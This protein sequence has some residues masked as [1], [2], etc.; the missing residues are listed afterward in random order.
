M[1][2]LSIKY[3]LTLARERNFTRAAEKLYITQQT[4]SAHIAALE[5]ET[6]GPLFL[7]RVPL[8]LTGG[9]EVFYRYALVFEE[10]ERE[11]EKELALTRG[12]MAGTLRIGIALARGR[13]L[14]PPIIHRYREKYP[15]IRIRLSEDS[16]D[17]LAGRL[18]DRELDLVIARFDGPVA[19]L[20]QIPF[21]EEKI[22]L[23]GEERF[24][25][26]CLGEKKEEALKAAE[27]GREDWLSLFRSCPVLLNGKRDIIGSSVRALYK[28]AGFEPYISVES[29][30]V[31]TLLELCALGEGLFFC[32]E[33]LA[34]RFLTKEN[35]KKVRL[36]HFKGGPVY[37]ISFAVRKQNPL[38]PMTDSFIETAKE[39]YEEKRQREE[40]ET[41]G[42]RN[43][44]PSFRG[45]DMLQ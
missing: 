29:E 34:K 35:L 14:L 11:L 16:N 22:I 19:G 44:P 12:A 37:P 18:E 9:G 20:K 26:K 4:L 45:K 13:L 33:N 23:L 32:A 36:L 30:N 40:R 6:G 10:N 41:R 15:Q 25:E 42:E 24:L 27:S 38:S 2:F 5:K 1:N 21:Y 39:E 17:V 7:R 8:E 31:E 3:F 28:N 43:S